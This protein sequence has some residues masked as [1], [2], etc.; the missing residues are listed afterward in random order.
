MITYGQY[1]AIMFFG[2]ANFITGVYVSVNHNNNHN[3]KGGRK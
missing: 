3:H 1:I 2:I